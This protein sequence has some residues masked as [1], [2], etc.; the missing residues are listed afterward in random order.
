MCVASSC[1]L[2]VY[3]FI[4][5]DDS[6][7]RVASK[8]KISDEDTSKEESAGDVEGPLFVTGMSLVIYVTEILHRKEHR[9]IC[10]L[11]SQDSTCW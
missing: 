6:E 7:C 8:S 4:R 1:I 2:K 9:V 5:K 11:L 10:V 3:F